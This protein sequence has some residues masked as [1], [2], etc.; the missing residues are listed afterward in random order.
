MWSESNHLST[1]QC[2]V[3]TI[4]TGTVIFTIS[5]KAMVRD[6]AIHS[7]EFSGNGLT[8]QL[9]T[10]PKPEVI[11]LLSDLVSIDDWKYKK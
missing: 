10:G 3:T 7:M 11:K 5:G 8:T 9:E 4:F 2:H 6:I 1:M